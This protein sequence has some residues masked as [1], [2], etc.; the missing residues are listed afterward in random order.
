MTIEFHQLLKAAADP[1][2][3]R[4][5]NLLGHSPLCVSDLQAVL[6]LPQSTVS[7]HLATLRHCGLVV[8][9]R[10]VTRTIYS[11]TPP[12]NLQLETLRALVIQGC[13]GEK[14]FHTD[15]ARL[16]EIAREREDSCVAQLA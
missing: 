14:I 1:T 4:I 3:L 13:N 5:L 10:R 9:S 11:L 2:R 12:R 8:G 15:V 16:Q 7:R 6:G